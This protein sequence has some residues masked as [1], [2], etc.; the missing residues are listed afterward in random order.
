MKVLIHGVPETAAV[1]APL[2][3]ALRQRGIDDIVHLSPPGFG[4]PAAASWD[5]RRET[6]RDWLI[7]ELEAI[8]ERID[9]LAHDWGAGHLWGCSP[10]GR[11]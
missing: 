1:W 5:A 2:V 7:A 3:G 8:D 9:I 6:Y 11:N 10:N 4:A